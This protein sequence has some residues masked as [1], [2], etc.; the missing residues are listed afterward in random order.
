MII[1]LSDQQPLSII[2]EKYIISKE[3]YLKET[4]WPAFSWFKP[5]MQSILLKFSGIW[6]MRRLTQALWFYQVYT[7]FLRVSGWELV[8]RL[9][10]GNAERYF[11]LLFRY[12]IFNLEIKQHFRANTFFHTSYF[13]ARINATWGS[14]LHLAS[15]ES[16]MACVQYSVKPNLEKISCAFQ[17][18][19]LPDNLGPLIK[20]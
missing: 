10:S 4:I 18:L 1:S 20:G 9:Q 17:E 11:E 16:L 14:L 7:Q 6:V 5:Y 8:S 12:H 3:H 19:G 13:S 2:F 15:D